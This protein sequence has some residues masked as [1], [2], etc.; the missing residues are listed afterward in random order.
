MRANALQIAA[1]R[2]YGEVVDHLA[3]RSPWPSTPTAIE[4]AGTARPLG[5][6]ATLLEK[7]T[8]FPAHKERR[9]PIV[10]DR[11]KA[12]SQ[13]LADGVLVNAEGAGHLLDGVVLVDL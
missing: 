11:F 6:Y 12:A 1:G 2:G 5:R 10:F 3:G 13:P 7:S 4:L 9:S 8:Q